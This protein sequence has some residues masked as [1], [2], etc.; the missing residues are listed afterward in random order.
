LKLAVILHVFL[1]MIV[2][3][4]PVIV[5]RSTGLGTVLRCFL[6]VVTRV[7]LF[8]VLRDVQPLLWIDAL[9]SIQA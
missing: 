9:L 8:I 5:I 3:L 4:S 6:T 7:R 2:L 1:V